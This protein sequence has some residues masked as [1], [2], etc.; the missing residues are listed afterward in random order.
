MDFD[1]VG[2][3]EGEVSK[4]V[5]SSGTQKLLD[6]MGKCEVV[7]SNCHRIRTLDR[8]KKD[9]QPPQLDSGHGA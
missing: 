5:Y 8:Q 9:N 2:D 3:K 6:E 7:C 4:L 1:H